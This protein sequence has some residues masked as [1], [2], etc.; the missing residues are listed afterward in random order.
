MKQSEGPNGVAVRSATVKINPAAPCELGGYG[1]RRQEW[2]A[3]DDDLEANIIAF[4]SDGRRLLLVSIDT[5]YVGGDLPEFLRTE[6]AVRMPGREVE[7]AV[8]A[9]HTH[10]APMLDRNKPML[11][12]VDD[13]YVALLK[14]KLGALLDAVSEAPGTAVSYRKAGAEGGF[15]IN[16][17]L[18]A[19]RRTLNNRF[20]KRPQVFMAPN[21]AGYV[22]PRLRVVMFYGS[23]DEPCA[24]IAHY[25]CH[26]TSFPGQSLVSS[27]YIGAIR[28]GI[29]RFAGGDI[30]VCFLQGCAGDVRSAAPGEP[31]FIS[32]LRELKAGPGFDQP[33]MAGW[34]GWRDSLGDFTR[35]TLEDLE[36]PRLLCGSI[37][38]GSRQIPLTDI[39]EGVADAGASLDLRYFSIGEDLELFT[40]NA[41]PVAG[42]TQM[43]PTNVM[44]AGYSG[45]CF[46]YLPQQR[47]LAVGGY[48]VVESLEPM[49]LAGAK[50]RDGFEDRV[51][52]DAR[53]CLASAA[54]SPGTNFR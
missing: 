10:F 51:S 11:G 52:A 9:S 17:R 16:R 15:S 29:R 23:S 33:S 50:W 6:A 30:P 48:E 46:G 45:D 28:A 47:D 12:V 7:V 44:V 49:N 38:A 27:D 31:S 13:R 14:R 35:I 40:M 36:P 42:W 24:A 37:V 18:I 5:L 32:R 43:F 41:E 19:S 22:D 1:A 39:L 54:I 26:P 21:P 34:R 8:V 4:D 25:G 3:I 2:V 20:S 53:A